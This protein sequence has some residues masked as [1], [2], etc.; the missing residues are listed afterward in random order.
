MNNDY[1]KLADG[2]FDAEKINRKSTT[3]L[4]D[5]W[6]TFK[7]NKTATISLIILF[8]LVLFVIIG[9]FLNEFDYE[10]NNLDK[11]DAF[12]DGVNWFGTDSLGRDLWTRVWQGGRVSLLIA[13]VATTISYLIGMLVGGISG[14]YGGKVDMI[15]MRIIDILMGIPE[16]VYMTLL[17]LVFGS[18]TV[19]TLIVAMCITGWMGPARSVRGLVLQMKERDFV[20]ASKTLGASPA[21]LIFKHLIPNSLGILVVGM[22]MTMPS[23]IFAEAFLSFIGLGVTPPAPSWG[24]L[25]KFASSNFRYY[26]YQ[27]LIPCACV[28]VTMLVFNLIGDGLRDALDPKLRG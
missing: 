4:Q 5:V 17:M 20:V 24:Q 1:E 2:Y 28:A 16:L 3:Y 25:I 10:T 18:G 23:Y 27:F 26:P 7:K 9:P 8:L 19:G 14:Y 13:L 11:M 22:T 12:P 6:R 15:I 21:R